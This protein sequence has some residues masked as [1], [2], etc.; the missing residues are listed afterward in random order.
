MTKTKIV[1]LTL[2]L[3]MLIPTILMTFLAQQPMTDWQNFVF[4]FITQKLHIQ[5][6]MMGELPLY[7][8][9]ITAYFSLLSSIWAILLFLMIY[10][11]QREAI[12]R[13]SQFKLFD[14]VIMIGL[15]IGFIVYNFKVMQWHF[16]ILDMST[17]FG[18]NSYLFQA[19]YQNKFGVILGELFFMSFLIMMQLMVFI[20]LYSIYST[21]R[22]KLYHDNL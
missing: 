16:A 11:D 17:R 18:R 21:V 15:V 6:G 7:T 1:F 19:M 20:G 8:V 9:C 2:L 3:F 12:P 14:A 4:R 10:K 22:D 13:L 5:T